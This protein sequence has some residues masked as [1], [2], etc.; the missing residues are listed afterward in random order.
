MRAAAARP[1]VLHFAERHR[2]AAEAGALEAPGEKFL[3]AA[4]LRRDGAAGDQFLG[5]CEGRISTFGALGPIRH[6]CR[7]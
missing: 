3:A 7:S 2:L 4:V 5:E 1:E 6:S